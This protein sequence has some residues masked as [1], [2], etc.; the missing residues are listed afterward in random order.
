MSPP[1]RQLSVLADPPSGSPS[2]P[3]DV[4]SQHA[5]NQS[6]AA[7]AADINNATASGDDGEAVSQEGRQ[8]QPSPNRVRSSHPS[9]TSSVDTAER[10]DQSPGDSSAHE[11]AMQ[12]GIAQQSEGITQRPAPMPTGDS[13]ASATEEGH[14]PWL[15]AEALDSELGAEDEGSGREQ[16]SD[17]AMQDEE[18]MLEELGLPP[19]DPG[20]G[21]E[22]D[23][24]HEPRSM[25][26]A[27]VSTG[28]M[29]LPEEGWMW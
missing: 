6:P 3:H 24:L 9:G 21:S 26:D 1:A 15:A 14:T 19:G 18:D 16:E 28:E 11:Y 8:S 20:L 29:E 5:T 13:D 4:R 7:A 23:F 2:L 10:P 12:Q 17:S 22:S 25:A 27:D